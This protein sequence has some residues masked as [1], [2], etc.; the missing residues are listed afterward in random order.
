VHVT[1][2]VSAAHATRLHA[3]VEAAPVSIGT[4]PVRTDALEAIA[5]SADAFVDHPRATRRG[6]VSSTCRSLSTTSLPSKHPPAHEQPHRVVVLA[7]PPQNAGR[8]GRRFAGRKPDIAF[9]LLERPGPRLRRSTPRRRPAL[10]GRVGGSCAATC[11]EWSPT[12]P[13]VKGQGVR[14]HLTRAY[15]QPLT[16]AHTI[17][18]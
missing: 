15:L 13:H 6:R 9:E 18:R 4:A 8:Q 7:A 17:A 12:P 5:R 2:N 14:R 11:G 10:P 16:T 3:Q 1:A